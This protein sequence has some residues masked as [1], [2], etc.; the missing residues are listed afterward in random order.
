MDKA[1]SGWFDAKGHFV[2]K[3]FQRMMASSFAIIGKVDPKNAVKEEKKV[4]KDAPVDNR[5]MEDKWASLLAESDGTA[6]STATPDKSTKKR[7]K[8][9][10]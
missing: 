4:D 5:S 2:V 1:F 8:K 6:A 9:A 7:G 10:A 3:P